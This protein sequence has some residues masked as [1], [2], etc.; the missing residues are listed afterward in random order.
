MD[1]LLARFAMR[2]AHLV[3]GILSSLLSL[4]GVGRSRA[5]AQL[6]ARR[7]AL[8]SGQAGS[9]QSVGSG[10]G[11]MKEV[12]SGE[13]TEGAARSFSYSPLKPGTKLVGSG[14][15]SPF[16][17]AHSR[18]S[19]QSIAAKTAAAPGAANSAARANPEARKADAR[20]DQR[21]TPLPW[22]QSELA[23]AM[24]PPDG[25]SLSSSQPHQPP[26]AVPHQERGQSQTGPWYSPTLRRKTVERHRIH[27]QRAARLR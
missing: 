1:N 3:L 26:A 23:A 6:T 25:E 13:A 17:F 10:F 24:Q 4:A 27:E 16:A 9:M 14:Q 7:E 21:K 8:Q 11:G 18:A 22:W 19:T 15:E 20:V 12:T 2:Y 5:H